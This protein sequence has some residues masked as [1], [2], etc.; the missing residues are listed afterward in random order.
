MSFGDVEAGDTPDW[1][2]VHR[3]KNTGL[4]EA[5]VIFA[6]TDSA[7]TD[8]LVAGIGK[9]SG[10]DSSDDEPLEFALIRNSGILVMFS[11]GLAPPHAPAA[12]ARSARAE[13]VLE[14][15]PTIGSQRM[16]SKPGDGWTQSV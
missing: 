13:E 2:V 4:F 9:D 8:G 3:G 16:E 14:V 5:D 1:L 10:N 12:G 11:L 6:R 15:T 7:P